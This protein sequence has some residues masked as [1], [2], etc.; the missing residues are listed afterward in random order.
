MHRVYQNQ[1]AAAYSFLYFSFFFLSKFQTLTFSSHFSQELWDLEDWNLAHTWTVDRCIVYTVFRLLLLFICLF[2]SSFFFLFNLQTFKIFVTLFSETVWPRR[3][4]LGTHMNSEQMYRVYRNQTAAAYSSL[5]FSF[6][7]LS[8]FQT[9]NFFVTLFL[10]TVR[11][12]RLKLGTNVDSWQMYCVYRN[13]AAAAY[14]SLCFFIFLSLN[15]HFFLFL[16][17][18]VHDMSFSSDSTIA[19]L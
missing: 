4:K 3:L 17:F 6:L 14:L 7:F 19:G 1:A 12:W 13:Q 10:G 8:N 11:P 2:I 16:Y 18:S 9:L 15:F 5:Y